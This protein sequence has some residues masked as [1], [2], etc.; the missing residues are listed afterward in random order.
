MLGCT[1]YLVGK[2]GGHHEKD[3]GQ[4]D[5]HENASVTLQCDNSFRMIFHSLR[6]RFFDEV[7]REDSSGRF[8]DHMSFF[9][10][11]PFKAEE[12]YPTREEIGRHCRGI[13]P[14]YKT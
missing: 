4:N 10:S 3:S 1:F 14:D 9:P 8:L 5:G 11:F 13:L 12:V 6:G 2:V 7:G